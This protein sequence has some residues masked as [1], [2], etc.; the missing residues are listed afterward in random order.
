MSYAT[1]EEAAR[2]GIPAKY[3]RQVAVVV[4][5]DEAVVAQLT[6]ADQYPDSYEIDTVQC[7]RE[8]AG[9]EAGSSS[10]GN[11]GFISTS[12]GFATVVV[13]RDDAPPSARAARFVLDKRTAT[14]PVQNGIVVA[15]FDEVPITDWP[16]TFP[17]LDEWITT[18]DQ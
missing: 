15:V 8:A 11:A 7:H 2:Q 16:A 13:W 5:G 9:W 12:A 6:N 18:E 1:P 10:N 14:F 3:V 4:R 17:V